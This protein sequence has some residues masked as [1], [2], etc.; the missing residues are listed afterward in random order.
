MP[1]CPKCGTV[2]VSQTRDGL[3]KNARLH[4][5][6]GRCGHTAPIAEFRSH[7]PDNRSYNQHWRDPIALTPGGYDDNG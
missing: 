4:G 7:G 1:I 6:C 5:V 2:R 3:A